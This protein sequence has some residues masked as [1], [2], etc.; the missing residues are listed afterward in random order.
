MDKAVDS[1]NVEKEEKDIFNNLR[2]FLIENL[3]TT[4]DGRIKQTVKNLKQVQRTKFIKNLL[5]TDDYKEQ[6]NNYVK[7]FDEV[8]KDN[9]K[10][11]DVE[12]SK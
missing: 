9:Q 5:L 4:K 12:I 1:L 7:T 3:D 2:N 6:V 10:Y 8:A 11:I